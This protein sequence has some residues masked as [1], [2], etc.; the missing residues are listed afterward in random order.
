MLQERLFER[1]LSLPGVFAAA[2]L[3]SVPGARALFLEETVATGP[4]EAFQAGREFAHIHPGY[5]GSLHLTL[6]VEL[7][8]EVVEKGWGEPHPVSASM[9]V[10]GPRDEAELEVVWCLLLASYRFAVGEEHEPEEQGS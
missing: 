10:Y 7:A 5:D 3:V 2:S 9:M 1:A 8:H 4:Q 6:P